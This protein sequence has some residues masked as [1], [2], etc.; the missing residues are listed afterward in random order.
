MEKL[1]LSNKTVD[2]INNQKKN[3][4]LKKNSLKMIQILDDKNHW[5]LEPVNYNIL[6][7][8]KYQSP[9]YLERCDICY[10]YFRIDS[11]DNWYFFSCKHKTCIDCYSNIINSF[12]I[13]QCPFCRVFDLNQPNN[14]DTNYI[15]H[16]VS[17]TINNRS[18]FYIK[19]NIGIKIVKKI[20]FVIFILLMSFFNLFL[21]LLFYFH[22]YKSFCNNLFFHIIDFL[23]QTIIIEF[24]NGL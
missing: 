12:D 5:F 15:N 24:I 4:K 19:L 6:K 3:V 1:E 22:I 16:D 7:K 21:I 18:Q 11:L 10:I 17:N 8:T 13:I 9:N 14:I 23:S 20:I 2:L